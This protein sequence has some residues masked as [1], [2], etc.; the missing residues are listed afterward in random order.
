MELN[1]ETLN[2]AIKGYKQYDETKPERSLIPRFSVVFFNVF[3]TTGVIPSE[4][5]MHTLY[6]DYTLAQVKYNLHRSVRNLHLA[7]TL[8]ESEVELPP[9]SLAAGYADI[10]MG[11]APMQI[12]LNQA[13]FDNMSVEE[14]EACNCIIL[15]DWKANTQVVNNIFLFRDISA[16][17]LNVSNKL[18]DM[19]EKQQADA[20]AADTGDTEEQAGE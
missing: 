7:L 17:M 20:E 19:M 10:V 3:Q 9:L 18:R 4:V 11:G 16:T 14:K 8:M 1:V 5:S 15:E 6:H 12:V 13:Q 2:A